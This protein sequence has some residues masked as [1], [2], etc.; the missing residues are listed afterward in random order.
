MSYQKLNRSNVVYKIIRLDFVN[1]EII[2][3]DQIKLRLQVKET[4]QIYQ[5]SANKSL[6]SSF[7]CKLW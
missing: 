4:L 2:G 7:E 1:S 6:I 5:Y 3:N